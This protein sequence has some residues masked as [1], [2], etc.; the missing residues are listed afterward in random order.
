[1]NKTIEKLREHEVSQ[2]TNWREKAEFRRENRSWLRRSQAIAMAMLDKMEELNL[3]QKAL[4]ERMGCS[5]QYVSKVLKG[6]ENL[7]LD[8]ICKIEDALDIQLMPVE[9]AVIY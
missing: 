4:S 6:H 9:A 5:Q 2:P 3:T 7:S 8:T 1:M